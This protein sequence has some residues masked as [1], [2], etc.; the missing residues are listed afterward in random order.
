[1]EVADRA[2]R[3]PARA[4]MTSTMALVRL[5][6]QPGAPYIRNSWPR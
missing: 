6:R 2:R 4:G 3:I 1:L 5:Q